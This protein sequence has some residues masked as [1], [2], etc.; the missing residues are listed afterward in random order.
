M[1]KPSYQARAKST[2]YRKGRRKR[3]ALRHPTLIS[4]PI[5]P[6]SSVSAPRT[7]LFTPEST[8]VFA[9]LKRI[10]IIAGALLLVLIVLSLVL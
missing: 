1:P 4:K 2:R 9:D 8:H 5:S 3:Q 10:G 6:P 7:Q